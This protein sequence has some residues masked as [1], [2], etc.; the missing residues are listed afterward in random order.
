MRLL[1]DIANERF[2]SCFPSGGLTLLTPTSVGSYSPLVTFPLEHHFY[3]DRMERKHKMK[4]RKRAL[5]NIIYE[6]TI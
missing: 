6:L 4:M 1:P 3:G 5:N 2:C